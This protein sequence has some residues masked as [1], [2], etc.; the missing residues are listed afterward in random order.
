MG[1]EGGAA[2]KRS[3]KVIAGL[4]ALAIGVGG[5][6]FVSTLGDDDGGSASGDGEIFLSPAADVGPDPYSAD[7]L[8]PEP[9]PELAKPAEELATPVTVSATPAVAANA[10]GT[11]G[12]YGGTKDSAACDAQK[13]VDFLAANPDKAA[14]WVAAL[15]AD[16]DVTLPD[17]SQLTVATIPD[18]VA[19]LTPVVLLEDTRV[20]NHG[21][22]DG[23]PT[24]IQSV[25]QKGTAVLVDDRGVPRTKCYCG[26]PLV[27]AVPSSST[28][29]YTGKKW[30]DFDPA[31]VSV[32]QKNPTPITTFTLTDPKT[33]TTFTL[34]AGSKITPPG[35]TG[36]TT[37]TAPTTTAP[38]T[39]APT[40]AA[41]TTA[42]T[43]TAPPGPP[44][45]SNATA[46]P[47]PSEDAVCSANFG[48]TSR[49]YTISAQYTDPDGDARGGTVTVGGSDDTAN[50]T[51]SGDG[52]SGSISET[53]CQ[54]PGVTMDI[55]MTDAAG[56]A[57]A[58]VSVTTP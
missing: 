8:A 57:S 52:T 39:A 27:P 35:G 19:T 36:T 31:K 23:K 26:N 50:I 2:R 3:T 46:T 14:A 42:P 13:L 38:T 24:K 16:P 11:P 55:V 9:D 17:G 10:G 33:G 43:T 49:G 25:L 40:T 4:L 12:L 32:V 44:V 30:P 51:F 45:L 47:K 20:T 1:S 48:P 7:P 54:D 18:Y 41:P 6:Y 28:P 58:P 22:K 5:G 37:T 29:R 53:I 15:D 34:T 21:F 56:N